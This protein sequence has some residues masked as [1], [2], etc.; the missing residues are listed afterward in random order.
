MSLVIGRQGYLGLAIENVSGTPESAPVV[1]L[2]FNENGLEVMSEKY[3][4]ISSRANRIMNH[5][6]IVGRNWTEGDVSMY[7]DATNSGYL[8]KL[9][10]GQEVK[11]NVNVSP[12]VD[13]HQFFVTASGNS[14]LTATLW[15]YRGNTPAVR[16]SS[17]MAVNQLD[18]EVVNDGLATMTAGWIGGNSVSA[19]APTLSTTSGTILTWANGCLRFGDSVA[20][21][22]NA[23]PT[24]ITNFQ[25]SLNNNVELLYRCGN[26]T[27]DEIVT[28]AVE[29]TGSYTLYFE[30][31]THLDYYINNSK[32]S[33]VLTLT[34][35]NLGGANEV[36]RIEFNRIFIEE[37]TIETG[38]DT[39]F[40]ITANFRA[41][42]DTNQQLIVVNLQ[43]GKTTV[44]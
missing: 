9:A 1:Y 44:Y 36:L 22:I 18:L 3:M 30:D 34:G 24:K 27:S 39:L 20:E 25:M 38:Q 28:G 5:D 15:N 26:N 2:P 16:R 17:R 37:K 29:V 32:K 6:S 13:N 7:L 41:I 33:M 43:N 12:A 23:N 19:S 42:Q 35:A 4:D 8:F 11:T 40:A 21:A 31:D 14:P 10:L